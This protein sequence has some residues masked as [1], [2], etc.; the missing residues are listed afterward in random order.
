[1]DFK[2]QMK[3]GF[4]SAIVGSVIG[5][6]LAL[7]G[8]GVW[9]L[10]YSSIFK[11][12][13]D[14]TLFWFFSNWKPQFYFSR[15]RFKFHFMFG[16]NM[17]MSN[18]IDAIYQNIYTLIIGKYFS[19]KQL[20]YF[21]QADNLK[22]I[23]INNIGFALNK[24]AL[25]FFS[26][27]QD[28]PEILKKNYNLMMKMVFFLVTPIL[29]FLMVYAEQIIRLLFSEKWL[30]SVPYFQILCLSGVFQS[31]QSFS[32][33][34]LIIKGKG[35]LY[36]R[37]EVLKKILLTVIV[38]IS[39]FYGVYGLLWGHLIYS[40]L[41]FLINA[42]F[43]GKLIDFGIKKQL[44]DLL[45]TF[46]CS[47]FMAIVLYYFNQNINNN[48]NDFLSIFVGCFLAGLLYISISYLF[49]NVAFFEL[50]RIIK[51]YRTK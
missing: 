34:L 26:K 42:F 11:I 38:I 28:N 19:I 21:N 37:I 18:L 36:F 5:I 16:V 22:Q 25:P 33:N 41:G 48:N 13:S 8:Y 40:F 17:L 24:I 44:I 32:L 2:T 49:K 51:T 10:V 14:T 35:K 1:M 15:E 27:Q 39:F 31:L 29:L 46:I 9:S 4:P 3:V 43:V 23:P 6:I 30:P 47:V 20:G 45:P 7:N 12:L 50:I